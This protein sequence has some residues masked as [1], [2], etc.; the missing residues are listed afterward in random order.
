MKAGLIKNQFTQLKDERILT[1]SINQ[2]FFYIAMI[3]DMYYVA[4]F[5]TGNLQLPAAQVASFILVGNIVSVVLSFFLGVFIQSINPSRGKRDGLW[6]WLILTKWAFFIS[7]ICVF[8]DSSIFGDI[9][10]YFTFAAYIISYSS[11]SFLMGVNNSILGA[12]PGADVDLRSNMAIW[13]TRSNKIATILLDSLAPILISYFTIIVGPQWAFTPIG[14]ALALFMFISQT[15]Y[16]RT[17]KKYVLDKNNNSAK[18]EEKSNQVGFIETFQ[19]LFKNKKFLSMI[20]AFS[21]FFTATGVIGAGIIYFWR[22]SGEFGVPFSVSMTIGSIC[23]FIFAMI[24]PVWGKFIGKKNAVLFGFLLFATSSLIL[25]IFGRYSVWVHTGTNILNQLALMTWT[26]F[27][28]PIM[29]DEAERY[30]YKTG[31][32]MRKIAPSMVV[33]PSRIGVM[34]GGAIFNYGLAYIGFDNV[35]L[36][37]VSAT[38]SQEFINNFLYIWAGSAVVFSLVAAIIWFFAY[39]ITDKDAVFYAEEN[40]KNLS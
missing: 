12:I 2:I 4:N 24:A 1:F 9:G 40:R 13:G 11:A 3:F 5:M 10:P 31:Q 22:V 27:L 36:E 26:A 6:S 7:F 15:I 21:I 34:I 29:M 14:I 39:K 20:I 17:Y 32:D 37:N 23:G 25:M 35:D 30:L 28:V 8:I 19:N 16:G 33:F 18:L 38:V